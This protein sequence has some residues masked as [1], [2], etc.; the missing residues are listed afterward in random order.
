MR[1]SQLF[2]K[3]QKEAPRD[4]ESLNAKLFIRAGFIHKEMAGVYS[5]L[6]LGLRVIRKIEGL[7]RKEMIALGGQEILMPAL[8]PKANWEQ[9]G[10]WKSYDSLF[11]FES[12][13]SKVE[14][15]LGPT[16]EEIV[17][18]LLKRFVSSYKELPRSVFQIQTKFR[19]EKRAKA[20]LMRSREFIMK[21]LYSFHLT[22][23][24]LERY[25]ERVKESYERIFDA[26]G[27]GG[28]TYVTFASGGTFSQYSHE[29][30][31]IA[32]SGEDI[33][34]LCEKCRVA[35]NK[36]IIQ[37]QKG[38]PECQ[39]TEL[40]ERK[41]VEVGNIFKLKT[42]YSKAFEFSTKDEKG[43]AHEV[44]MGCYGIGVTRLMATVAEVLSDEKGLRWP[45]SIAPFQVH[46]MGL[47][48]GKS[49]AEKLYREFETQGTEVFYDD[50]EDA[51]SGEKLVDADLM[52]IPYRIVVSEKTLKTG[53][54]ELKKRGE[55]KVELIKIQDTVHNLKAHT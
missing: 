44:I 15:A 34:F 14:Y 28:I 26:V 50:R 20:G 5:I 17:T 22:Q 41:A 43:K 30:Q 51:T 2:T 49:E 24:D 10:R 4:E 23:E 6:P 11:R 39:S 18:P 37:E 46:L 27:I 31:T 54:V 35:V 48:G 13:Y 12:F 16:H 32:P 29:F 21:D 36:E 53:A 38:C 33:I 52:G 47:I 9:T 42:T 1:Y 19:D 55:E 7:L 25:Y 8:Q 45:S 40:K 3:T